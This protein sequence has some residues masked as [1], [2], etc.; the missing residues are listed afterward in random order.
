MLALGVSAKVLSPEEALARV[1]GS[2]HKA[3]GISAKAPQLVHTTLTPEG[4]AAVYVFNQADDKGYMVL[5]ADDMAYP[6]LGYGQDFAINPDDMPEQM[7][8]WLQQY[9]AQIA[10]AKANNRPAA[11]SDAPAAIEGFEAIPVMIKTRWDQLAP[12]N[13]K[14]PKINTQRA[15]TGCVATS[16]AQVMKYWEYPAVGQGRISYNDDDGCGKRLSLDFST[17]PFDWDNM[18]DI[19]LPGK[20]SE[21]EADAVANLMQCA[22]Y[23]VKMSYGA[24]SSGALAMN[25]AGALV[26]YF[27]YDPNINYVYRDFFSAHEWELMIL[28]NLRDVGP[29]LYGGA[30]LLGGGHSFILDGYD[31]HGY[32]HFNWGWSEMSD[33]YYSLNALNP[34]SLGAG[35][36]AG[37]GYNFSQDAVLGIQPPTG[38]PVE[39]R[40]VQVAQFGN[41]EGSVADGVLSL[42]LT[43]S[44]MNMWVN[45]TPN[46]IDAYLGVI[47]EKQG[48]PAAEPVYAMVADRSVS[49]PCG[50]GIS[51]DNLEP[52]VDLAALNLEDGEYKVTMANKV[53]DVENASWVPVLVNYGCNNYVVVKKSGDEYTV[54]NVPMADLTVVS[55]GPVGKLYM[56]CY[57]KFTITLKNETDLT[58][59]RGFA[60]ILFMNNQPAF[61]GQSVYLTV[62]PGEEITHEWASEL[63]AMS[64]AAGQLTADTRMYFS[65]FDEETYQYR[66]EQIYKAVTLKKNPGLPRLS[67]DDPAFT[68]EGAVDSEIE[69]EKVQIGA[70]TYTVQVIENT[71][72]MVVTANVTNDF[73]VMAYPLFATILLPPSEGSDQAEILTYDG[74]PIFLNRGES[75]EFKTTVHFGQAQPNQIY[76]AT[77]TMGVGSQLGQIVDYYVPFRLPASLGV[78][79]VT[80]ASQLAFNGSEIAAQGAQIEVYNL[81]GV[82]VAAGYEAV[83][84]AH[85]SAG[86]YVAHAAG[87]TLKF[88]VK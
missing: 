1:Q 5:S 44:G 9:A 58:L 88:A 20:Y 76:L 63:N 26:K 59:T 30:S 48:T 4:E 49:I 11:V 29:I 34:S 84:I 32:F 79:D 45:Y 80:I 70:N 64:D 62:D 68:I 41:L 65:F 27:N 10:F 82:K 40:P 15:P 7:Q 56:D 47:I 52:K 81:Q 46:V 43:E 31:G 83:S 21:V 57:N 2:Q 12:Y 54:T 51:P 13:D 37:G 66:N 6:M 14:C 33:G 17:R 19:Y 61:L 35:G 77:L 67:F 60:P 78:E 24:D 23:S 28:E 71:S 22:G 18:L 50:Y 55:G 74:Y 38:K 36:G 8:W 42:T 53:A 16:M 39:E 72:D 69:G 3:P 25:T 73:G 87:K 85:L 86:I 75:A